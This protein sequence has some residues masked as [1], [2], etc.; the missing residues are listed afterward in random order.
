MDS[1]ADVQER[2]VSAAGNAIMLSVESRHDEA[3]AAAW[4]AID[5]R[6]EI[7]LLNESVKEAIVIASEEALSVGD[8]EEAK[9]VLAVVEEEPTGRRP[10]SLQA[11][12]MRCRARMAAVSGDLTASETGLRGAVGLFREMSAPFWIAVAELELA[13]LLT[14]WGRANEAKEPL[15]EAREIFGRLKAKAWLDRVDRV[16]PVIGADR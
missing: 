13:E 14:N 8:L 4:E 10:A 15:D 3:M 2:A 5:L 9:R 16:G 11:H 12:V 1:S 6:G 7:G